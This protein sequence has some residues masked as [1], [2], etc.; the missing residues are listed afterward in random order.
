M[1]KVDYRDHIGVVESGGRLSLVVK[2]LNEATVTSELW[3]Q[4]FYRDG[5]SER[6]LIRSVHGTGGPDAN[7]LAEAKLAG[8]DPP[9]EGIIRGRHHETTVII[10]PER[11]VVHVTTCLWARQEVGGGN[12]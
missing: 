7:A 1:A 10:G 3:A 2:A 5:S 12:G 9:N 4:H 6:R 8:D 11:H